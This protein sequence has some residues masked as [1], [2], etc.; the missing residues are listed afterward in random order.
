MNEIK[1]SRYLSYLLRHKPETLNL[2]VDKNG[3]VNVDE[4][5]QR[6]NS[7][8]KYKNQLTKEI[9]EEIVKNDDKQRYS[10]NE[11]KTKIRAVQ[12]HSFIVDTVKKGIPPTVLYH[13]TTSSSYE[14]IK[15]KGINKMTRTYVHL[16]KDVE[17]AEKVAK[18]H[19]KTKDTIVVLVIDTKKM[20]ADG[21]T[22]Y[23]AENG[24]WLTEHI[25]TKYIHKNI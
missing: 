4:L 21:Y 8:E 6:V 15:K 12:G 16:S 13:G 9:L 3:Y 2:Y 11:D 7:V 17:T 22:F 19:V 25:P 23:V 14:L 5:I 18:R 1:L 20:L 10:Y 24:V